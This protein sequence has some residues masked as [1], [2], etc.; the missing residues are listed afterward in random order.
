MVTH[1]DPHNSTQSTDSHAHILPVSA[2]QS[3]LS[4]RISAAL[5]NLVPVLLDSA[6]SPS[7]L[8]LLALASLGPS[9]PRPSRPLARSLFTCLREE[10]NILWDEADTPS[11][12]YY[13][14]Y[15]GHGWPH[16]QAI[17]HGNEAG[18]KRSTV[19]IVLPLNIQ[20]QRNHQRILPYEHVH[21]I[22]THVRARTVSMTSRDSSGTCIYSA[23]NKESS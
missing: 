13:H 12:L 23:P 19:A 1:S 21:S 17:R 2:Q 15:H 6:I 4:V 14:D 20:Y 3:L 9:T 5:H 8:D 11:W 22:R 7:L 10:K 18:L 16:S